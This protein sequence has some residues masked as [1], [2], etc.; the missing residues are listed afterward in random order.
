MHGHVLLSFINAPFLLPPGEAESSAHQHDWESL[1]MAR[2]FLEFGYAV[3]VISF[4]NTGFRPSRRYAVIVDARRNLERLAPVLGPDCL[5]ILHIDTAHMLFH[6]AAE[7]NRLLQ[8]QQRRGVTLVPRRFEMP[9]HGIEHAD[10]ATIYGN[11]FTMGT[12]R[13]AGKPLYPVPTTSAVT[14]PAP[15]GKDVDACRRR[16]LW[17][18]SWG[19]VHKGLDL[20]LEAFAGMPDL[21]LTVCGPVQQEPDFEAAFRRE[22]YETPNIRTVGWVDVRSPGFARIARECI[23]LVY[24][25]CSEGQSGAVVTCLHA[26]LIPIVSRESGVDIPSE[27][28]TVLAECSVAEI[29]RAARAVAELPAATLARMAEAAWTYARAHHTREKFAEDYR[30]A[31]L[32]ILARRGLPQRA[33]VPPYTEA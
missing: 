3:D 5:K 7:A 29:R 25:S 20:V 22:L 8:L 9:N 16:F 33:P 15:T 10:C 26:G 1:Q 28:G 12:Y 23:A 14:F 6:N 18:G 30:R 13:Y 24:P 11:A 19:M 17:L 32:A 2:T 21:H 27:V 4:R 31:V